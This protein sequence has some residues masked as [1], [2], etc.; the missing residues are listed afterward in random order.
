M[1][2][3]ASTSTPHGVSSGG[4][5]QG[6]TH[7]A[8]V[9]KC[10]GKVLRANAPEKVLWSTLAAHRPTMQ[11]QYCKCGLPQ[12]VHLQPSVL[13]LSFIPL[14]GCEINASHVMTSLLSKVCWDLVALRQ[15]GL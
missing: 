11:I 7:Y 8:G 5:L 10:S 14:L 9:R 6:V 4:T 13:L 1:P 12:R 15:G 3:D 2:P